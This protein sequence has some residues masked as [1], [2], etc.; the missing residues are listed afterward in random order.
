MC[1]FTPTSS[2]EVGKAVKVLVHSNT[3]FAIRSGG[4]SPLPNWASIDGGV[5]ISLTGLNDINY[6][7]VTERLSFGSGLR[8]GQVYSHMTGLGRVPVGGRASQVGTGGF[9]TGG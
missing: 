6:D 1:I 7:S 9:L 8:W 4:H 3:K 5:L 2:Q